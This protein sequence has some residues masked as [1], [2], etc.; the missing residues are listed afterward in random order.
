MVSFHTEG[1]APVPELFVILPPSPAICH[2]SS[3]Q[4]H[5]GTGCGL[6]SLLSGWPVG[7]S[8]RSRL[9]VYRPSHTGFDLGRYLC[10]TP[11]AR[12]LITP[13]VAEDRNRSGGARSPGCRPARGRADPTPTRGPHCSAPVTP[14]WVSGTHASPRGTPA[15]RKAILSAIVPAVWRP[16]ATG[17]YCPG[18]VAGATC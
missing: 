14:Q 7:R 3:S 18:N 13:S 11:T 17:G 9:C 16:P 1:P 8:S 12:R 2:G 4:V 5:V 15:Q 10:S 6:G